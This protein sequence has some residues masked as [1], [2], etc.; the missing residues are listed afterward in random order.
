MML[1]PSFSSWFIMGMDLASLMSSV[2]GLNDIPNMANQL[3]C[4]FRLLDDLSLKSFKAEYVAS[5]PARVASSLVLLGGFFLNHKI[6]FK[7]RLFLFAQSVAHE[8]F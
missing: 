7:S 8:L 3:I 2:L 5:I 1:A 4:C 6:V